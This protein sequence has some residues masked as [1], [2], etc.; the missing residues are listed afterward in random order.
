MNLG[1]PQSGVDLPGRCPDKG[2]SH[3]LLRTSEG[4]AF[5]P[6]G[7]WAGEGGGE[8]SGLQNGVERG[9]G[10]SSPAWVRKAS[11]RGGSS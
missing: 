8:A 7:S 11:W 10:D 5:P 6:F 2:T 3:V 4:L 9:S 1:A